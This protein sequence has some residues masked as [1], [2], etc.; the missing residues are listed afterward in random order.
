MADVLNTVN[1]S[2]KSRVR[3]MIRDWQ[4]IPTGSHVILG[5]SGGADSL[6]LLLLLADLRAE[7]SF[8]LD[9]IHVHHGLRGADADADAGFVQ[10]WCRR[11]SVPCQIE[12]VD[13]RALAATL[14]TGLEDAGRQARRMSFQKR[15]DQIRL[16]HPERDVRVALAHHR[17]DQAE[18]LLLHLGRGS[19]LDGLTAMRPRQG[20]YIRPLLHL[21]R[22]EIESWLGQAKIQWRHDLTNRETQMT[23]NR[24]RLQLLPLW[25]QLLGYDPA[26]LIAS[27]ADLLQDDRRLIEDLTRKTYQAC[28]QDIYLDPVGLSVCDPALI[29]YVLRRFWH[30]KTDHEPDLS[31]RHLDLIVHWLD[32]ARPGQY[33]CL[34]HGWQLHLESAGLHLRRARPAAFVSPDDNPSVQLNI[35]GTTQIPALNFR[36]EAHLI[37]NDRDIVYNSAMEC[38]WLD[39]LKGCVLRTRRAG[40]KI[41]LASRQGGRSLKKLMNEL[42]IPLEWRD[43]LPLLAAGSDIIWIPGIGAGRD[44]TAEPDGSSQEKIV[45]LTA[46]PVRIWQQDAT[47]GCR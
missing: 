41:H 39:R 20:C 35:P 18:T 17:D 40:D 4:L 21:S 10:D 1:P 24:V 44:Y 16:E 14:G 26:P 36:I 7:L 34:P 8:Y 11:L 27:T 45:C 12:S 22:E 38:F 30:E 23:R 31:R 29:R 3:D 28:L 19:G 13:V 2:F 9:V 5:C 6:A 25:R 46:Q 33:L 42:K 15:I 43:R 32:H 47:G 37:E